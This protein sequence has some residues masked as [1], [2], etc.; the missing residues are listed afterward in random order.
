MK[1]KGMTREIEQTEALGMDRNKM[2]WMRDEKWCRTNA[3][4]G[5]IKRGEL[6]GRTEQEMDWAVIK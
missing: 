3:S 1:T 5:W 6:W 4:R 2:D